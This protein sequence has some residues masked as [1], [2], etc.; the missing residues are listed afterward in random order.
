MS[1]NKRFAQEMGTLIRSFR[2]HQNLEENS[3][4]GRH[5][6]SRY[7]SEVRGDAIDLCL[8]IMEADLLDGA[9]QTGL[10][11]SALVE[12]LKQRYQ[13][14]E[15][16][17]PPPETL[18]QISAFI[19]EAGQFLVKHPLH[20]HL[21]AVANGPHH[22]QFNR[23]Q[24]LEGS[25]AT[26]LVKRWR[27]DGGDAATIDLPS[28]LTHEQESAVKL[29]L[30]HQFSVITGGPGTGKTRIISSIILGM[31]EMGFNLKRIL[32][33]APTGKAAF[34]MGSSVRGALEN[35]GRDEL[36]ETLPPPQTLHR[37]LAF[38]G[39][40]GRYGKHA[41]APLDA[42]CVIID[43]ASMV[44]TE[45]FA[46]FFEALSP[47]TR[48]VLLG[49]PHQLPSVGAGAVLR[50]LVRSKI[51]AV[52][53]L[54][55]S[56]RMNPADPL[57]S[58]VYSTS[59]AIAEANESLLA[60]PNHPFSDKKQPQM[61]PREGVQCVMMD[62]GQLIEFSQRWFSTFYQNSSWRRFSVPWRFDEILGLMI[63]DDIDEAF[64]ELNKARILCP[65]HLGTV[66]TVRL[67]AMLRA[68]VRTMTGEP[69]QQRFGA[70]DIVLC[71]QNLY[72]LNLFNGDQGVVINGVNDRGEQ[73]YFVLFEGLPY[74]CFPLRQLSENIEPA[75]AM[76]VHKSQ[77]SEFE[78]IALFLPPNES[79]MINRPLLYTAITRAKREVLIFGTCEQVLDASR[80]ELSRETNL[81]ARLEEMLRE[82]CNTI[83][84]QNHHE[85]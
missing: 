40:T 65:T 36:Y 78:R 13:R 49:D 61:T 48:V 32:L 42:D 25:L 67:N 33:A 16:P 83:E 71:R 5:Y 14:F 56:F 10:E 24:Y 44:D 11:L 52:S 69:E 53:H 31:A 81:Q 54:T 6:E 1:T 30:N 38:S 46:H 72:S 57:G 2:D 4:L 3:G 74:R 58:A 45:M 62:P 26:A 8:A 63:P 79:A 29:A 21:I 73:T 80:R 47:L 66:G 27:V 55:H 77:G 85:A 59:L 76:S 17:T 64:E 7:P 70:G 35:Q 60:L 18:E 20:H 19:I 82:H 43:E 22:I 68:Q 37:L 39:A 12:R 41:N 28:H 9:T 75:F 34:R 50:D 51:G 23:V 84:G 15:L